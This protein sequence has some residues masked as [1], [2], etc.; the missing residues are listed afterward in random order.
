MQAM[1]PTAFFARERQLLT[2]PPAE[3]PVAVGQEETQPA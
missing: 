1:M 3:R 2:F